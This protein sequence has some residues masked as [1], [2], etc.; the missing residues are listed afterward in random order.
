MKIHARYA[1]LAMV[2]AAPSFVA[3]QTAPHIAVSGHAER[4]VQPD[5]FHIEIDIEAV[6]AKPARARTRVEDHM[7]AV[8]AAFRA[9]HALP[10]SIDAST[11]S[12]SPHERTRGED[13][14][15]DGTEVR[16]TASATFTRMEDLRAFIDGLDA[17]GNELQISGTKMTRSDA[18]AIDTELREEAMHDSQRNAERIAR[19]YDTKLGQV[20]SVSDRAET[21][22][23]YS[24]MDGIVVMANKKEA[25]PISLET[26][27]L[28][29][30]RTI[31]AIFLLEPAK[32]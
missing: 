27:G 3:A 29:M 5:R 26:G 28:K 2:A 18:E 22:G 31:Y 6:D 14:V 20:F 7:T 11:I 17:A 32:R 15:V 19:A 4:I 25:T 12:I 30:Q 10:E 13:S 16:R 1:L 8:V 21:M 9:N 24:D 23:G